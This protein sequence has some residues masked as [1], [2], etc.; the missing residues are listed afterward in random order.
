MCSILELQRSSYY[1]W[2]NRSETVE[3]SEN[4][5]IAQWIIN[6]DE[7]SAHILGYRRMT[8]WI[9]R[10]NHKHYNKKRIR[11][12]MKLLGIKS[13]IRK[14]KSK[15]NGSEPEI[16]AEN[17]L[18]RDFIATR[19]N[20]KWV[21]DVTEFKDRHS[22]NKLYLSAIL[23]LYDRSI[24]AY[25]ISG[26]NN[27]ELVFKTFE[28]AMAKNPRATPLFHSDRGFQYTSKVFKI[29]L[30]TYGLTQSMSRVGRCIDNGPIEGFWGIIK[31]E[32]VHHHKY[33]TLQDLHQAID[34][35]I[36]FYNTLRFQDRFNH[37]T[38]LEVREAALNSTKIT[39]YPIK[40]NKR[41]KKYY[42][43]LKAKQ[44][45]TV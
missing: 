27:N 2:L 41:I 36:Y 24:V 39:Q 26:R 18:A 28:K 9:N 8:T 43:N 12:I 44:Q 35:Y 3:E 22:Q 13:V 7:M 15:Y 37:Q 11:R 17:I 32:M 4:H 14:K 23:D 42:E 34:K 16:T 6:Y 21:T 25:E 33:E 38:P 10:L 40:E 45:A 1:K 5:Q 29:K 19:P 31:S 20:E 30:E